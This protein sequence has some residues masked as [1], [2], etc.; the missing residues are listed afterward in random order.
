MS[1]R[2][3]ILL[4]LAALP[5]GCAASSLTESSA[6]A[7]AARQEEGELT[8]ERAK[9]VLT[10]L[11]R[12]EP[13][14]FMEVPGPAQFAAEEIERIDHQT[15]RIGPAVVCLDRKEYNVAFQRGCLFQFRGKFERRDGRWT[16]TVT[17]GSAAHIKGQ[18]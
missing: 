9:V 12:A 10:D 17:G 18:D 7:E 8:P 2:T 14:A 15:Y 4:L 5:L 6:G 13:R 1:I 16:A 11:F 3:S